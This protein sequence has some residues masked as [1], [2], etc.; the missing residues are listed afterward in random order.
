MDELATQVG[1]KTLYGRTG[2][3]ATLAVGMAQIFSRLT[4]GRW[5]DL[6]YH[7]AIMFEALFILTT[8][9]AGTR[10]ARFILQEMFGKVYKPFGRT[11]WLPGNLITSGIVVLCWGYFIYTGSVATIWPMFGTANQLLAGIALTIGTSYLINTGKIRYAWVTMIP[12]LFVLTVTF[13]AGILNIKLIYIPELFNPDTMINR[14]INLILTVVIMFCALMIM[15]DSI[16]QWIRVFRERKII[17]SG[18]R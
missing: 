8:I 4:H 11:D 16:P 10:V 3:A 14:L 13:S 2:G 5:L 18:N 15:W 9:D 17:P 12:M 7:F 6:W 1:E